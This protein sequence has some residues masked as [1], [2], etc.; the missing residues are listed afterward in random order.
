MYVVFWGASV[1]KPWQHIVEE[2][3]VPFSHLM[4][5]LGVGMLGISKAEQGEFVLNRLDRSVS[6]SSPAGVACKFCEQGQLSLG[7]KKII[8]HSGP[9]GPPKILIIPYFFTSVLII[10]LNTDAG[11]KP[12]VKNN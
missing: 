12:Q 1:V 4:S 6:D 10:L 8:T 9:F 7:A 5:A 3:D 11:I 2:F